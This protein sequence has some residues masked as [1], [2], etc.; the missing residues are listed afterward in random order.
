M[1]KVIFVLNDRLLKL[2]FLDSLHSIKKPTVKGGGGGIEIENSIL[3]MVKHV[4]AREH[5]SCE[6]RRMHSLIL[7]KD[8]NPASSLSN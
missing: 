2:T 1:Y 4:V 3:A 5:E 6:I 7:C 8:C